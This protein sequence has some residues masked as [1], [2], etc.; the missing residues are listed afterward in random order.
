VFIVAAAADTGG[1]R[2]DR[3]P[4]LNGAGGSQAERG[5]TSR[6]V[7]D[8]AAPRRRTAADTCG[9]RHGCRQ[10]TGRVGCVDSPDEVSPRERER[11]RPVTVDRS[12]APAADAAGDGRNERRTEP[13]GL[14]GGPDA[15]QRG[16]APAW[17]VYGPA[18]ER[19]QRILGRPAPAPTE[20]GRTGP[21][22]SPRLV[23]WLQGLPDGW[24]TGVPGLSRNAQ[25]RLLG[26]GVVPQ[27]GALALRMLG[28]TAAA[29][30]GAA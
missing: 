18:I 17:G 12:P 2:R 23:E 16:D 27:Q 21:R 6:Y 5:E 25:L 14:V 20:P 28:V 22:L 7:G 26:N 29:T 24:V 11:P 30:A 4:A 19:W 9:Q 8:G 1:E 3:R 10:D 15:A 13:A